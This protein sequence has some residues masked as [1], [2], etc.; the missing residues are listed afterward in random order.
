MEIKLNINDTIC[1][2]ITE[3]G[4]AHLKNTK[5]DAYIEHC[6]KNRAVTIDNKIWY[7]LQIHHVFSL[8]PVDASKPNYFW[9]TML[10]TQ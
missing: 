4:W 8:F 5:D 10:I 1:I 7:K 9:P 3:F 6:V 2:Q